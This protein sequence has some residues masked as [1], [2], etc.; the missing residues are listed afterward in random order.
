MHA[1]PEQNS[2][3]MRTIQKIALNL[4]LSVIVSSVLFTGCAEALPAAV[5]HGAD[6]IGYI[7][8]TSN[9]AK[10]QIDSKQAFVYDVEMGEFI[11]K[12]GAENIIYPASTTK[13]LTILYALTILS[14]DEVVTPGNEL[15]LIA[16][17]SSIAYIKSH[18]SLTVEMLIEGMLLPSGNDA[19]YTL[20]AAAGKKLSQDGN[21][22][23]KGAVSLFIDGMNEYAASIGLCGSSF[24][25]PDGYY[26]SNH[27]TTLE[28][29]ALISIMA[30]QNDIIAKYARIPSDNVIYA[31]GH[32]NTWIN[33]NLMLDPESQFYSPYV[34]GLKTG[35]AGTG[36]Y[37]LILTLELDDG[38]EYIIGIFSSAEKNDRYTD[39][40]TIIDH[41]VNNR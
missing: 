1:K 31:S 41:L 22:D 34:T 20:A 29:I 23:G 39:A 27:Y 13:L 4:I 35:S 17:D 8:C 7:P 30:S 38:R 21:I 18:H 12:K 9:K 37:S 14:L 16:S 33:T 32:S 19:A 5:L 40:L 3:K 10:I 11:Y 6:D 25:S 36:N 2:F 28:D 26:A 15:E 24:T